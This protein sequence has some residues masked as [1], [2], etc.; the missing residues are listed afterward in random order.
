MKC[1]ATYSDLIVFETETNIDLIGI[2]Y[3]E[4]RENKHRFEVRVEINIVCGIIY[5]KKS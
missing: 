2:I 3:H 4:A 1:L 5:K